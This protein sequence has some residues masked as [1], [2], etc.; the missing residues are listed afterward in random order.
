MT[1]GE[2]LLSESDAESMQ[3]R[4]SVKRHSNP[5]I[6]LGTYRRYVAEE[7]DLVPFFYR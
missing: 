2:R 4:K 7:K 5:P 3:A 6:Y 1:K